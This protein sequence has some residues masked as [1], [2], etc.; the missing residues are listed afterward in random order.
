MISCVCRSEVCACKRGA[1]KTLSKLP[2]YLPHQP[3]FNVCAKL[4][5][6]SLANCNPRRGQDLQTFAAAVRSNSYSSKRPNISRAV[7]MGQHGG[8]S[9]LG[10]SCSA[11]VLQVACRSADLM[12]P[13]EAAL[14]GSLHPAPCSLAAARS[15]IARALAD[16]S[17]SLGAGCLS[18]LGRCLVLREPWH[19]PVMGLSGFMP[20]SGHH[21]PARLNLPALSPGHHSSNR[22][23]AVLRSKKSSVSLCLRRHIVHGAPSWGLAARH[24]RR[25]LVTSVPC[26]ML[27]FDSKGWSL[28]S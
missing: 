21:W 20:H 25:S 7:V 18:G 19:V 26:C 3:K 28:R 14:A 12:A 17:A 23:G 27:D 9:T 5:N 11:R 13:L 15:T 1:A 10:C 24:H 4:R 8:N 16:L 6:A 2:H 22:A